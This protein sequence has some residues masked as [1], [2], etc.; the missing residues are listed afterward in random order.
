MVRF[1]LFHVPLFSSDSTSMAKSTKPLYSSL[2]EWA[3]VQPLEQYE[4][5]NPLAPIFYTDEYKDATS[6]FRGI[7]KL[8]EMSPRVLDL[9]EHIIRLNPA[10]Y[11]AWYVSPPSRRISDTT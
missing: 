4:K 11:T 5:V 8:G 2:D 6:Y 1:F 10:H 9:T 3:D 7:V